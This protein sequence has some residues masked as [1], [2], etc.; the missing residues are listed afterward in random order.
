MQ[1][2]FSSLL[3][4]EQFLFVPQKFAPSLVLDQFFL[5]NFDLFRVVQYAGGDGGDA[6]SY[7]SGALHDARRLREIYRLV[8][9]QRQLVL[10]VDL[11][12]GIHGKGRFSVLH[13]E[14]IGRLLDWFLGWIVRERRKRHESDVEFE[15]FEVTWTERCQPKCNDNMVDV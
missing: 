7:I 2:F 5:Q 14:R 4:V 8:L 6:A 10:A 9:V 1:R 11:L 3:G 15:K 12:H 13:V